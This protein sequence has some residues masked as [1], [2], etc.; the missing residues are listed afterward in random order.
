MG[1]LCDSITRSINITLKPRRKR[2][3][4]NESESLDSEEYSPF[5]S[6]IGTQFTQV[7]RQATSSFYTP[8]NECVPCYT[9]VTTIFGLVI[10]TFIHT[11]ALCTICAKFKSTKKHMRRA[12]EKKPPKRETPER[13]L[14]TA[15]L[16][17][18]SSRAR[19][20]NRERLAYKFHPTKGNSHV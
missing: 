14:T 8:M 7:Y 18:E 11:V 17:R 20:R 13:G 5:L 12:I 10:I 1:S 16:R 4:A 2:S 6:S 15:A 9:I 19:D 3:Q